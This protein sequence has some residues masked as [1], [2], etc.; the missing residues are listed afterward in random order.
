MTIMTDPARPAPWRG[1]QYAANSAHHRSDDDHFLRR[2]TPR[3]GDI[4]VDLGCGS[5][6]FTTRLADLV[7]HGSVTGIDSNASM[8]ASAAR[9]P[10]RP[11]LSF[12]QAEATEV[13]RVVAPGS[14]DVVVSRA[15]L[16]WIPAERHPTLY[17][18]VHR[19]LRPGGTFHL[20]AAAPRNIAPIVEMLTDLAERYGLPGPPLFPD[21]VRAFE[22]LVAAGF[23]MADDSVGTRVVR[24]T[25]DGDGLAGLLRTQAVLVLTR[26]AD[27]ALADAV[28]AEALAR[29]DS[30]R[31]GDGSY[32]QVFVRLE[33]LVRRSA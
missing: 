4:V 1:D 33:V 8:L 28:T 29:L 25:F 32:D 2:H 15:M 16:H 7:R 21:P 24:R 22:S 5:G 10:H 3:Q 9:A 19:V 17:R 12:V 27:Q 13:D 23:E 26:H 6:E 18:A 20:E 31:S 14:V 30:L 11:N